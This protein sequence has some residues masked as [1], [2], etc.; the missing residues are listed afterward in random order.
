MYVPLYI[1]LMSLAIERRLDSTS[2]LA[3]RKS[4]S[5]KLTHKPNAIANS[6]TFAVLSMMSP[7]RLLSLRPSFAAMQ[8]GTNGRSAT[9]DHGRSSH[10][11]WRAVASG[12]VH[13]LLI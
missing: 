4:E 7:Q 10:Q 13:A 8:S 11:G 3:G 6:R 2:A 1:A 5:P 12:G 9:Q